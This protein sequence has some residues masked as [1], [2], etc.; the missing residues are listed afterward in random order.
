M[1]QSQSLLS[2]YGLFSGRKNEDFQKYPVSPSLTLLLKHSLYPH[3]LMFLERYYNHFTKPHFIIILK[4]PLFSSLWILSDLTYSISG[5]HT[6]APPTSGNSSRWGVVMVL[7][8][9][10]C[11]HPTESPRTKHQLPVKDV[12]SSPDCQLVRRSN[13]TLEHLR[14]PEGTENVRHHC[15]KIWAKKKENGTKH[16]NTYNWKHEVILCVY[17]T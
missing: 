2:H 5:S 10:C 3:K 11:K 1:V 17:K 9:G 14:T 12:Y 7:A 13:S 4:S 16:I 8:V 15:Q 6:C